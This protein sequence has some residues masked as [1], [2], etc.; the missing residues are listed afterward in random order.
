MRF[1][2]WVN[3]VLNS[4][5]KNIFSLT[6]LPR[7]YRFF[8]NNGI[9]SFPRAQQ[10]IFIVLLQDKQKDEWKKYHRNIYI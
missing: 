2:A 1:F 8:G 10:G 7:N 5:S 3:K 6:Y 9:K 4:A